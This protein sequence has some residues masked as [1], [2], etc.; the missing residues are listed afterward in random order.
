MRT[1]SSLRK[2]GLGRKVSDEFTVPLCRVHHRELHRRSDEPTWR[3]QLAIDPMLTASILWAQTRLPQSP[4]PH[5]AK[6]FGCEIEIISSW[7]APSLAWPAVAAPRTRII[8]SSHNSM[9]L[10]A[11]PATS[12]R[13]PSAGFIIANSTGAARNFYGGNS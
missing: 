7:W 8:S 9:H 12:S 10:D 5:L 1:I 2:G 11:K 13:Y 4:S 3:Q 6:S